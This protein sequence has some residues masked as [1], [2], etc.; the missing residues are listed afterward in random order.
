MVLNPGEINDP[1]ISG[2]SLDIPAETKIKNLKS[3]FPGKKNIGLIYSAQSE[4]LYKNILQQ[5]TDMEYRL[6]ARK[7]ESKTEFPDVLASISPKAS[8]EPQPIPPDSSFRFH[9]SLRTTLR[10]PS[11]SVSASLATF[12]PSNLTARLLTV[13]SPW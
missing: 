7:I 3:I 11:I 5:C 13:V 4:L 10:A 12:I 2:V 9:I 6:V 1:N 8:G